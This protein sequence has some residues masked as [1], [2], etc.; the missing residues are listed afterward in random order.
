MHFY[1]EIT[2]QDQHRRPTFLYRNKTC[3]TTLDQEFRSFRGDFN[4]G[5]LDASRFTRFK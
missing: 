4:D 5:E 3:T 2:L 1:Q